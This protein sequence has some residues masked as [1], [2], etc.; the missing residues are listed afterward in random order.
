MSQLVKTI[1]KP[2]SVEAISVACIMIRR[3]LFKSIGGF[4]SEYFMYAEDMDLCYKAFKA[5]HRNYF[6][7]TASVIHHG[8]S[9]VR[10]ARNNFAVI[11]ATDS[12]TRYFRKFHG[13]WYAWA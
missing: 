4:S 9:S 2:A 3:E 5:G 1:S 7:P 8:D 6:L 12:L 11:M 13:G 10:K